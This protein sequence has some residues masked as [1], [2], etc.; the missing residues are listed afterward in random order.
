MPITLG[1][2][3]SFVIG[4]LDDKDLWHTPAAQLYADFQSHG[5]QTAVF[6]C[7]LAESI[8]ALARRVHEKRRA[9]D[10][11]ALFD[12][13]KAKFP[14]KSITWL[15]P[16]LPE[17]YDDV[18]VLVEQSA[19]ELNFND[20]LI[21]LSCRNKGISFLVSFDADFDRVNWLKRIARPDQI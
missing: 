18:V 14:T 15:Y 17:I 11:K 20:A 10:L 12:R 4:L 3:T 9:A 1:L 5:F 19:G 16:E 2:D 13:I 6:D 8:S 7:V 21:A